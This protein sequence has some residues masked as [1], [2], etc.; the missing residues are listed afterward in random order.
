MEGK[1]DG[2]INGRNDGKMAGRKYGRID[3]KK[4]VH[5]ERRIKTNGLADEKMEEKMDKWN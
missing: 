3:R 2:L 1:M 5:V 4:V